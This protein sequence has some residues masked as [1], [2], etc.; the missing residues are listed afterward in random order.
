MQS[1]N[2]LREYFALLAVSIFPKSLNPISQHEE[3]TSQLLCPCGIG[4]PC[5]RRQ[6]TASS[7]DLEKRLCWISSISTSEKASSKIHSKKQ[8]TVAV[9]FLELLWGKPNASSHQTLDHVSGTNSARV[10]QES[11]QPSASLSNSMT[12]A[13]RKSTDLVSHLFLTN[14]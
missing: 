8:S 13:L 5:E 2:I 14:P 11:K 10:G 1:C 4:G 7:W 9:L 6:E 3:F 12:A